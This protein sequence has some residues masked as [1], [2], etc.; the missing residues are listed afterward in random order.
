MP[1]WPPER[2]GVELG[3]HRRR[4]EEHLAAYLGP[5][6][7][8]RHAGFAGLAPRVAPIGVMFRAEPAYRQ[9]R[10]EPVPGGERPRLAAHLAPSPGKFAAPYVDVDV[11]ARPPEEP[12]LVAPRTRPLPRCKLQCMAVSPAPHGLRGTRPAVAAVRPGLPPAPALSA[13]ADERERPGSRQVIELVERRRFTHKC[14]F[15]A[16]GTA[17]RFTDKQIRDA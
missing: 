8:E 2:R 11:G 13:V 10:G 5:F 15:G 9:R 14:R 6:G 12:L 4:K 3:L 1:G 16:A 17:S 7:G